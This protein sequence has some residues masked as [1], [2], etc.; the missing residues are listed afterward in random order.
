MKT[1]IIVTNWND[2][3]RTLRCLNSLIKVNSND[4]DILITDNFS[5]KSVILICPPSTNVKAKAK[6]DA[7]AIQ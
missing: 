5:K 3:F 7:A 6:K 2:Q 1:L 4:F